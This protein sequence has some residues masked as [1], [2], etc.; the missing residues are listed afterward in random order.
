MSFY[1]TYEMPISFPGLFGPWQFKVSGVLSEIGN[2]IRWYGLLIAIGMLCALA[3]CVRLAPRYKLKGDDLYDIVLWLLPF[4][5]IGARLYYVLFYLDLFKTADGGFDFAAAVRIWDGGL[6]I[7]GGV[8][9]GAL[10]IFFFTRRR[11]I[12][13]LALLDCII[14]G[15]MLG[16]AIGRWGNF[17]NREAY[18]AETSV[19]WRM[20][21]WQSAERYIDVHPTFFYESLW[22]VVGLL[23]LLFVVAKIRKFN[24]ENAC[25]YFIWY[26]I[27]RFFIE[28]LR[29]DSLYFF[30]VTLFGQPLRVSQALS[31]LLVIGGIAGLIVGRRKSSQIVDDSAA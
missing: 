6:A 1:E 16:Q 12:P 5:I 28:G 13:F 29:T 2:G 11:R 18:G 20:R 31:V 10:V 7:Y 15:L 4:G 23:L 25:F 30:G 27:G 26:G 17:M 14:P 3:L 24:G 22:N 19:P 21:L 9:A 8:I